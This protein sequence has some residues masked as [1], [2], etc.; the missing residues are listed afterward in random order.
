MQVRFDPEEAHQIFFKAIF[1]ST[2]MKL[3]ICVKLYN[4]TIFL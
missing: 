1:F 4:V 3:W 2:K